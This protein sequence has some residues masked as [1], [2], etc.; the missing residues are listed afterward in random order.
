MIHIYHLDA[1]F[2]H[3]HEFLYKKIEL[4]IIKKNSSFEE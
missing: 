2:G 3:P 4:Q 1:M